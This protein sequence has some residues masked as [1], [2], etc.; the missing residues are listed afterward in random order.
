M[1]LST[2]SAPAPT[3]SAGSLPPPAFD[4]RTLPTTYTNIYRASGSPEELILDF[5]LDA[6]RR[7]AEGGEAAVMLQRLVLSWGSAKRLA[8][9]LRDLV[10]MHEKTHGVI[11]LANPNR[12]ANPPPPPPQTAANGQT[13]IAPA[14]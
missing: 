13:P 1:N 4:A 3:A 11:A 5:G 6:H 8:V 9:M 10:Q 14:S 12:T 2:T 7:T